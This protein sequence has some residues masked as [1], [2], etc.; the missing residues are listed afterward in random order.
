MATLE[1]TAD[2]FEETITDNDVSWWTS[3][4]TGAD[5]VS[6]LGLSRRPPRSTT[7]SS[8]RSWIPTRTRS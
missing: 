3:G 6:G 5:R 2:N 7:G 8:S 1:I 4:P